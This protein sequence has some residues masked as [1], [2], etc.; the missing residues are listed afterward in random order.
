MLQQ[1]RG[2]IQLA[3]QLILYPVWGILYWVFMS[4]FWRHYRPIWYRFA[5]TTVDGQKEFSKK[6]GMITVLATFAS[7]WIVYSSIGLVYHTTLYLTTARVNEIVYLSNAQEISLDDNVFSVQGCEVAAVG[8]NFSCSTDNSLYFR[9]DP[10]GFATVWSILSNGTF[11]YPDYVAAPIAPGW[12]KCTITSYGFRM[13]IF[14]R[15]FDIYPEL[16]SAECEQL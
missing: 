11:F 6:R 10:T 14:L 1:E 9:I 4:A 7:L 16:L 12:Q 13:K 2:V 5:Y 15:G 8:E 3:Y